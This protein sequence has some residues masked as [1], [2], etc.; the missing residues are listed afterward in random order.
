MTA[1]FHKQFSQGL[2]GN[3]GNDLA[4][5]MSF[6]GRHIGAQILDGLDSENWRLDDY[7]KRGGYEALR[8]ILTTGMKPEDVIAEV[9]A[10]SLRGR[11]DA[12]FPTGLQRSFMPGTLPGQQ[13]L[14]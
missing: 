1:P 3:P 13:Y 12:G 11:G 5:S 2:D 7:V 14:V 10:S 9:K 6:H 8:K 4:N